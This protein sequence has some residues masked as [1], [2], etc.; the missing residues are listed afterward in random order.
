[1]TG[2]SVRALHHYDAI[3][4]LK[5]TKTT[6]AGY[7]L[8]DEAALQRLQSI[9]LFRE[10][11]FPLK[12]IKS[13]LEQK[14]FDPTRA[15]EQQIHLLQMQYDRLGALIDHARQLQKQGGK[16]MEFQVFDNS[17]I[18]QYKTEVKERWGKTE[19]Y[20][21]YEQK[22]KTANPANGAEKLMACFA[23]LGKLQHLSP[24]DAAVQ[25]QVAALQQHISAN[26][27]TC[28]TEIFRQLG[29]MYTADERFRENIDQYGGTGT[30]EFASRAIAVYCDKNA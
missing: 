19:A 28:T 12:E 9:L 14:D 29:Q 18:E 5:P 10:L 20:R 7:R 30:A 2:V 21:E 15:L 23:E 13:M 1:M 24:E 17:Q 3:G 25:Q 6:E 22:Q 8:Y 16:P 11:Q 4:L 26:Y 27:Y